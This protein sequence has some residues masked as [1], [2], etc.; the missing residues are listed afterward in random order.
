MTGNPIKSSTLNFM[1]QQKMVCQNT[2]VMTP[3]V[4]L[5]SWMKISQD[6]FALKNHKSQLVNHL[7]PR[8]LHL[9]S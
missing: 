3:D 1:T 2:K 5:L 7:K 6:N 8:L 9:K 4:K